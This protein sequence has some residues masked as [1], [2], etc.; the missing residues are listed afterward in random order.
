M[1]D[2]MTGLAMP[3]QLGWGKSC[4]I[5]LRFLSVCRRLQWRGRTPMPDLGYIITIS[6]GRCF[7]L[8]S[9]HP[10]QSP[11]QYQCE[12]GDF[13]SRGEAWFEGRK[14]CVDKIQNG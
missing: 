6:F 11:Q 12:A 4:K 8:V 14:V 9:P 3:G 10:P 1:P 2:I 13:L 5:H 7:G